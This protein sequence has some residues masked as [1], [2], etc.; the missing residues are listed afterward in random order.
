MADSGPQIDGF[1]GSVQAAIAALE[2]DEAPECHRSLPATGPWKIGFNDLINLMI[3]REF[4]LWKMG[5]RRNRPQT[6]RSKVYKLGNESLLAP[7]AFQSSLS[8]DLSQALSLYI[9]MYKDILHTRL[10]MDICRRY[11][12]LRIF[13]GISKD[14]LEVPARSRKAPFKDPTRIS[15]RYRC[16]SD[17]WQGPFH[18]STR[19]PCNFDENPCTKTSSRISM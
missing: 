15:S 5:V 1:D 17:L 19:S 2:D 10:Y 4:Y 14:L 11:P 8:M 9:Y 16:S 3:Q 12:Y 7:G 18:I 6:L 13:E